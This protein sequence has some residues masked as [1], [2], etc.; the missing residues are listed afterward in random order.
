M[1]LLKLFECNER[2]FNNALD[3]CES[4]SQ[5]IEELRMENQKIGEKL[6]SL[7]DLVSKNV[8]SDKFSFFESLVEKVE[9]LTNKM[10]SIEKTINKPEVTKEN[11]SEAATE[12]SNNKAA[13]IEV[14][15]KNKGLG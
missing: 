15:S 2:R 7:M 12:V 11:I 14:N 3:I 5:E 1:E 8:F 6:N 4:T 10:D 13:Y 9:G